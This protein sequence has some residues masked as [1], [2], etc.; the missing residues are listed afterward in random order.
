MPPKILLVDDAA[1]FVELQKG[2]LQ[3][4]SVS[5]LTARDG[6]EALKLCRAEHPQL[7][8]MDL[9]MPI[10]GGAECCAA[11]K[12]DP[13][14]KSITVILMTSAGKEDDKARCLKAGCNDFLTKPLDRNLYLA[15]ARS[16]LP[17][18][19]RRAPRVDCRTKVKFR[20]FG[21]TLSG[22]ILNLS[23]LG[24]YIA[25]DY[26]V[27]TGTVI[28]LV[29]ALPEETGAII[30]TKGRVVWQNSKTKR[31]KTSLPAGFGVEFTAIT[32]EYRTAL[33]RYLAK[34]K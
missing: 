20:V 27:A 24:I 2:F 31:I 8:F 28:E 25:T 15:L 7:V 34:H 6:A 32:D 11:L 29:F 3:Q 12:A 10:M 5:I 13:S 21:V 17:A 23:A 9:H 18:I 14:L 33:A 19:D 4:S 26:E 16:Y 30:Q 22:D 1:M